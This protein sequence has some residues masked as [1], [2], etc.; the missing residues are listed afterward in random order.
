MYTHISSI[1][2]LSLATCTPWRPV[3]IIPD[4]PD[5]LL[6]CAMHL[7]AR[8]RDCARIFRR[9][10][11]ASVGVLTHTLTGLI[12]DILYGTLIVGTCNN[13]IAICAGSTRTP[14]AQCQV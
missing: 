7:T 6:T 5:T 1:S 3:E 4:I 13:E 9:T 8:D 14:A 2:T 12:V 10:L 11:G